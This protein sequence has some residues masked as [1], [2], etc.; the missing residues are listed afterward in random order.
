MCELWQSQIY[1][2][3]SDS[4]TT[5]VLAAMN[6]VTLDIIGLAGKM[7]PPSPNFSLFPASGG[8]L[9]RGPDSDA[10]SSFPQGLDTP[11]TPWSPERMTLAAHSTQ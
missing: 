9:N 10:V 2:G 4:M 11:L 6:R 5:D 1:D 3:P 8:L 7:P